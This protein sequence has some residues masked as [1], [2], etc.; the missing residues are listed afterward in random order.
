MAGQD[1]PIRPCPLA[2]KLLPRP[3]GREVW[4]LPPQHH[5][6]DGLALQLRE[7]PPQI[8]RT[9]LAL[10]AALKQVMKEGVVGHKF[11]GHGFQISWG[12]VHLGPLAT[13]RST[14]LESPTLPVSFLAH[15]APWH[16]TVPGRL[17]NIEV[18]L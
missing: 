10:L 16:L 5:W 7:L 11:L 14:L 3:D 6:F 1:G 2:Q 9:P 8:E 4:P 17:A 18:S 15:G 12:Q 13:G